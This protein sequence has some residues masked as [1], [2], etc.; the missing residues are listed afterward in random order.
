MDCIAKNDSEYLPRRGWAK[1]KPNATLH[2]REAAGV[3]KIMG[4]QKDG[5][6]IMDSD[7]DWIWGQVRSR[8]NIVRGVFHTNLTPTHCST[9]PLPCITEFRTEVKT[10]ESDRKP[11]HVLAWSI[12]IILTG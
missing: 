9:I 11:D 12:C 10:W 8:V 3:W 5:A 1:G 7:G 4:S 6:I 2:S